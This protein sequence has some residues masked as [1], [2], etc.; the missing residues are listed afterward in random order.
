MESTGS[1]TLQRWGSGVKAE[2]KKMHAKRGASRC[3]YSRGWTPDVND[4]Q[5]KQSAR[6]KAA[7]AVP[8]KSCM[9]ARTASTYMLKM[10]R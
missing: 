1:K 10:N 8:K 3:S 5:S 4:A 9:H 2:P 6:A 7:T